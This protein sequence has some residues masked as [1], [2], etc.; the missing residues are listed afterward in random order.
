MTFTEGECIS[1]WHIKYKIGDK[2]VV[3]ADNKETFKL[4]SNNFEYNVIPFKQGLIHNITKDKII[5]QYDIDNYY[6]QINK[7]TNN[8]TH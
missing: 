3:F 6:E 1:L 2:V 4:L 7:R 5:V 8:F